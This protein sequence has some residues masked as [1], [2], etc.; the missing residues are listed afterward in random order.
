M[1]SQQYYGARSD[2]KCIQQYTCFYTLTYRSVFNKA[3]FQLS[4]TG[5]LPPASQEISLT[6]QKIYPS[7]CTGRYMA[8]F[9][10]P[11]NFYEACRSQGGGGGVGGGGGGRRWWKKVGEKRGGE[12]IGGGEMG[13]KY[14]ESVGGLSS[15]ERLDAA[16]REGQDGV[17]GGLVLDRRKRMSGNRVRLRG[18]IKTRSKFKRV[19]KV[20][21]YIITSVLLV[22]KIN[23]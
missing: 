18:R 10:P 8:K 1:A 13:G 15:P 9:G 21:M 23:I 5:G 14:D 19:S 20:N 12:E 22:I 17:D 4:L 6:L 16:V 3:N 2:E 7:G 11:K